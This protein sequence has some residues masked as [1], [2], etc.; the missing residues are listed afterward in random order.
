[1]RVLLAAVVCAAGLSACSLLSADEPEPPVPTGLVVTD[2][3]AYDARLLTDG[4]VRVVFDVPYEVR[5]TT[6]DPLYRI[7][8][9]TAP[10]PV[11]E[12]LVDGEWVTAYA[13]PRLACLSPPFVVDE[14]EVRRD[15][16]GVVGF[17]PGQNIVPE[18]G[19]EVKGTYRLN[20]ELF[21]S[22][23]DERPP[24]GKDLLPPE[25]R[26]SNTFTVE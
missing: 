25:S 18:F 9:R 26:V 11:L 24:L 20:L 2:R 3:T 14:G 17:L 15:T 6:A 7:G 4:R 13:A 21:S 12:K 1:M 19:T 5:N 10:P 16:L 8:C 22:L 23:T